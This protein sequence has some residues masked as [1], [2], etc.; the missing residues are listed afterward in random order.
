MT[1]QTV[2]IIQV[3]LSAHQPRMVQDSRR[4]YNLQIKNRTSTGFWWL[5]FTFDYEFDI[6]I[7]VH[8][9]NKSGKWVF[10]VTKCKYLGITSEE[11]M[12]SFDMVDDFINT[13]EPNWLNDN[14][15][16]MEKLYHCI[17]TNMI[18]IITSKIKYTKYKP[19]F[20]IF[21]SHKTTDK[22]FMRTFENGL[23]FLGYDKWLDEADMPLGA[24]LQG[25]L[26]TS[27]EKSDC[28]LA[29]MNADFFKSEFCK[30]ELLYAHE[31]GKI[32]LPFGVYS[33]IKQHLTGDLKFVK[34]LLTFDP[35]ETSFF[36]ILRRIDETLFN[37]E[38][39]P[40]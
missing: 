25:A 2:Y 21:L 33:D 10:K 5:H 23:Q 26:K 1:V 36:E 32:I 7:E 9:T 19:N 17:E 16:S 37:F 31:K 15:T 34:K 6:S 14:T 39:L 13:T 11:N 8:L 24:N 3:D 18:P 12:V 22:P 29:W 35:R 38:K 20:R 27:I 40:L 4:K 28:L 30:A